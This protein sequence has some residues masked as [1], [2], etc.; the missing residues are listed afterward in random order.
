M[1]KTKVTM[2]ISFCCF[3][4]INV[5]GNIIG[6]YVLKGVAGAGC[7]LH[8]FQK[9]DVFSAIIITVLCFN[10]NWK[11]T[12]IQKIFRFDGKMLKRILKYSNFL[13]GAHRKWNFQLV[14]SGFKLNCSDVW[15]LS[16]CSQRGPQSIW[17]LA[18]LIG[19]SNGAC[20]LLLLLDNVWEQKDVDQAKFY[21]SKLIKNGR[22]LFQLYGM[23]L[24]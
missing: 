14:K 23:Y 1:A 19:S 4:I 6:V 10:K 18:A 11:L 7:I 21:F 12:M 20:L 17:S 13:M 5:V 8:L 22:L 2:Y 9:H 24:F 3:N 15:N 16:N